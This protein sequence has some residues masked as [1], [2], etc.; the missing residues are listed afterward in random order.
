MIWGRLY[1]LLFNEDGQFIIPAVAAAPPFTRDVQFDW[2]SVVGATGYR[3]EIG[4]APFA[5]NTWVSEYPT[6]TAIVTLQ[7]GVYYWRVRAMFGL[8][9]DTPSAEQIVYVPPNG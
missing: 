9:P 6:N 2:D 1:N 7:V 5:T 4:T 3:L 8:I